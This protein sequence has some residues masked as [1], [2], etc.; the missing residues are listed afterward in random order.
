MSD[1]APN[2]VADCG[3]LH[4]CLQGAKEVRH[5]TCVP[6]INTTNVVT[7]LAGCQELTGGNCLDCSDLLRRQ[8][9]E[10][11]CINIMTII[12]SIII[13]VRWPSVLLVGMLVNIKPLV[14]IMY[15]RYAYT[16]GS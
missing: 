8:N 14:I 7:F 13:T 6:C 10:R 4:A 12:I 16:E 3:R 11:P 2:E 15:M 9:H 5:G 1:S